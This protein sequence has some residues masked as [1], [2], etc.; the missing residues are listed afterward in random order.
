MWQATA[1]GWKPEQVN[2]VF[3]QMVGKALNLDPEQLQTLHVLAP[4][5]APL[6]ITRW[7]AYT[8]STGGL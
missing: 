3:S 2:V 5:C 4:W 7:F 8:T 1:S 6:Y